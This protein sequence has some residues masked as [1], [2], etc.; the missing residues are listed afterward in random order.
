[1]IVLVDQ[2]TVLDV[3]LNRSPWAAD[4]AAVWQA[5]VD[6][7]VRAY[8]AAFTFPT[9]FYIV[10]K[11]TDR[12]TALA[13]VRSCLATFEVAP[14]DHSTL[15]LAASYN[16]RDFEDDLQ[17]ACAVQVSADALVSRDVNGF[18]AA[19]MPVWAPADLV[20]RLPPPAAG[21]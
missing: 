18:P 4:A 5:Q 6:G 13:A 17:L 8:V 7:R 11:Q 21:P 19:P 20:T 1:V 9:L 15:A 10:R 12:A 2:N 3:F 14:V 16:G